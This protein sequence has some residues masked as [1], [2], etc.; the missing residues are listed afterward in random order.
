MKKITK[1]MATIGILGTMAG[2]GVYVYK[3]NEKRMQ[4]YMNYIMK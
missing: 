4:K 1:V 3:S 2:Y